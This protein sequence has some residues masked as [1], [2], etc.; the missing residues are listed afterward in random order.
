MSFLRWNSR[1]SRP[2]E[3]SARLVCQM[4]NEA[5]EWSR[6][7]A[8]S[9]DPCSTLPIP[10]DDN[11]HPS[12][13]RQ[14]RGSRSRSV[15]T[16]K[17]SDSTTTSFPAREASTKASAYTAPP[18]TPTSSALQSSP[19]EPT[20]SRVTINLRTARRL[21]SIPSASPSPT[22]PSKMTNN[23]ADTGTRISVESESDALSTIPAIETPSSSSSGPGSPRIELVVNDQDSD[24]VLR[25]PA[26]AIFDEDE[27]FADPM[28]E[29][30]YHGEDETL[31]GTVT[32][33]VRHLQ[34]GTCQSS[35]TGHEQILTSA[36][37]VENDDTFC[38]LRDWIHSYLTFTEGR[39]DIFYENYSQNREFWTAFPEIVF[40]LSYR[41]YSP[42]YRVT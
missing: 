41:R 9:S 18:R 39:A 40:S 25:S 33:L 32:R 2:Y 17:A 37:A 22:T 10:F 20:S 1:F 29:F 4:D 30:P 34:Y 36:D 27:V 15:D 35:S 38:R 13:K 24:F 42:S 8:A 26:L 5:T 14:R 3:C 12:L 31:A 7:R 21:D 19:T 6:E 23:G 16:A 11:D 28:L